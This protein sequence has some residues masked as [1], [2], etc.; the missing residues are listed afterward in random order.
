M[1]KQLRVSLTTTLTLLEQLQA[2]LSAPA[3][4][5]K[6][7]ELSGKDAL[8]LLSTSA[9]ALKSQVTKLSL[10]TITSP[11]T[12]SA[13]GTVLS[14]LNSSVLPSLVTAAL[15]VTPTDH[16]KAFH[17]E[18]HA[19]AKS[20]LRELTFLVTEVQAVAEKTDRAKEGQKKRGELSQAEKDP[21]TVATGRVWDS[22]DT[23]IDVAAKGVVGFV[24]RRVE[25]W[26]DLVRDAVEEIEDWD[27]EEDGDEFFDDL[28]SDDGAKDTKDEEKEEDTEDS[29][30]ALHAQKK[31]TLRI[32]KPI[33]QIYPA[34]V[35]NRLK[36]AGD[37]PCS[38]TSGIGRLERLMMNLQLI[39]EHVDEVAG[40]LYE[41]DLGKC[42]QYLGK[43]KRCAM[44][45]VDSVKPTWDTV[46][47]PDS[48]QKEDKFTIWSKTWM[49]V[50]DE[51]S[52]SVEADNQ[53]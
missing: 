33:A 6:P 1:A 12:H 8:P 18:I 40:A 28:L 41:E 44:N 42:T 35:A 39:P 22:C 49:N 50:L 51:V 46:D 17:A 24:I 29:C 53:E 26:R 48:Q 34:I 13:V 37:V 5:T 4:D 14:A 45:A 27:P 2:A 20:T 7:A 30:A 21:V 25:E 31:S 36:G 3:G 43:V 52:K 16:T 23:L 47:A 9:T 15:L 10:L 32:L 11:F 38:S 19:L